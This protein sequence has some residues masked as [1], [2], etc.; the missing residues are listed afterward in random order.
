MCAR[1]LVPDFFGSMRKFDPTPCQPHLKMFLA[2]EYPPSAIFLEY[3]PN[4]EMISLQT[5]T[6]QRMQNLIS[7]IQEINRAFVL[8]N[9]PKPRNMMVVKDDPERVVWL[10]FDRAKTYD[11]QLVT[12]EERQSL[13]EEVEMVTDFQQCLVSLISPHIPFSVSHCAQEADY[14]IGKLEQAY[15]F[16]CT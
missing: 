9:D 13:E 16:Y 4:L 8:H 5:Y 10:D 7:A 14:K 12:D 11:E 3:I 2:D 1:G 15:I 6:P